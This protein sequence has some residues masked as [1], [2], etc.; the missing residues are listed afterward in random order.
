MSRTL[1][2]HDLNFPYD[3]IDGDEGHCPTLE[4]TFA[5]SPET[6]DFNVEVKW[7]LITEWDQE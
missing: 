7:P 2:D 3:E 6:L 1:Y 5:E 4:D